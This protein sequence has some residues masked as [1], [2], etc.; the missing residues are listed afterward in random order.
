MRINKHTTDL[1]NNFSFSKDVSYV[2]HENVHIYI[3]P[4]YPEIDTQTLHL[5]TNRETRNDMEK[6]SSF[7][8]HYP[9]QQQSLKL[10]PLFYITFAVRNKIESTLVM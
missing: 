1:F 4:F 2:Q 8:L 3:L 10:S 6:A 7:F 9:I 5:H